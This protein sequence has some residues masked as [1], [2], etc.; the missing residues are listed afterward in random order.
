MLNRRHRRRLFAEFLHALLPGDR[1]T[2]TLTGAGVGTRPL[3]A[4][5]KRAT[6]AIATIAANIAQSGDV[7]LD[8]PAKCALDRVLPVD[9]A[10]DLGQFLFGQLLGPALGID[11]G[12]LEDG[13]AVGAADA[14][15]VRQT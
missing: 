11:P 2:R 8:L 14:V 15:D 3:T 13:P 4:R 12:F 5:R 10:D 9:N 6:V 7:L 1:L